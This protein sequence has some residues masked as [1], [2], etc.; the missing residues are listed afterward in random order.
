MSQCVCAHVCMFVY[1]FGLQ[2]LQEGGSCKAGAVGGGLLGEVGRS[3]RSEMGLE[4]QGKSLGQMAS[5]AR[6]SESKAW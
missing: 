1:V 5:H 4:G 3:L 6:D 2:E